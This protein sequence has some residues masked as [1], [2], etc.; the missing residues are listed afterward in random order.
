MSTRGLSAVFN[1]IDRH[2][3]LGKMEHFGGGGLRNI[4]K[5]KYWHWYPH[6]ALRRLFFTGILPL[7]T[8][9]HELIS[10]QSYSNAHYYPKQ[11]EDTQESFYS[12]Q[13]SVNG[14]SWWPFC[15]IVCS[16]KKLPTVKHTSLYLCQC[17]HYLLDNSGVLLQLIVLSWSRRRC[18]KGGVTFK[19]CQCSKIF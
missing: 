11:V 15:C 19:I 2:N 7:G 5:Y 3:R 1:D 10:C 4:S 6:K 9:I 17:N 14:N 8:I 13:S 16:G 18:A 12:G